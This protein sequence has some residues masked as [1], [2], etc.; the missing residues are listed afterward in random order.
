[1]AAQPSR[2]Y[3]FGDQTFNYDHSLAQL[4]RSDNPL[5]TWFFR[6][7]FS[8]LNTELGRLPL[9]ARDATP[10]FSSIADLLTRK[11]DACI[12]PALEQV[13]CLVHAFAAF[14]WSATVTYPETR[15]ESHA[16]HLAKIGTTSTASYPIL[17]PRI[18]SCWA[19]ALERLQP[20]QSALRRT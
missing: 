8:A 15:L 11:R 5:L 9:N 17:P 4:L 18:A 2:V 6:K 16:N 19:S 20:L 3:V 10:K 12:S 1:M 7:C 14:I 13:L